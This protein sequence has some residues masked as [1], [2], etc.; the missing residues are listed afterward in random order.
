MALPGGKRDA[1]DKN[2]YEAAVR[3]CLEEVGL[4]LHGGMAIDCGKLPD[5][6]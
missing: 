3:E 5:R 2:D 1:E 6:V 4:N